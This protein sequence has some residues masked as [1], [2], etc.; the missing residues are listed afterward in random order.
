[1]RHLDHHVLA[2]AKNIITKYLTFDFFHPKFD[3]L[4]YLKILIVYFNYNAAYYKYI[5]SIY[6]IFL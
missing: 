3:C 6:L 2:D 1:M 4:S 5:L